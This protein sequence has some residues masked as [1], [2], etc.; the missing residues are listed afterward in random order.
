MALKPW[1]VRFN[2][3]VRQAKD[4]LIARIKQAGLTYEELLIDAE[5][6]CLV[7]ETPSGDDIVDE[8]T[9]GALVLEA[10]GAK[11]AEVDEA[12][13]EYWEKVEEAKRLLAMGAS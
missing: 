13:R 6:E 3:S 4:E 5:V 11:R 8:D 1:V 12:Y 2:A 9:L 10:K 7:A